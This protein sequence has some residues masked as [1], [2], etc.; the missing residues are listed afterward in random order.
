MTKIFD[1]VAAP[2][3]AEPEAVRKALA[4]LSPS[5]RQRASRFFFE[6]DRRRF[7][8]ARARLRQLLAVR[9]EIQP[10]EVEL[11]YGSHGKPALT[12]SD[13]HFNV[14]H[15]DDLAV[16]A[17]SWGHEIGVD[18]E[19]VRWFVDAGDIALRF[20]SRRENVA[21]AALDPLDKPLGFFNCWT[22]KEAFIKALGDG[23][24]HP[25]DRFD[26]SLAPGEP[27]RILRVGGTAG[28]HCGWTLH[29]LR[30]GPGLIAAI[31]V[32]QVARESASPVG[33]E[34]S[35]VH[36]LPPRFSSRDDT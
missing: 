21:Y 27:A 29:S 31:V 20:F 1:A 16:Y 2:L 24:N 34:R 12:D 11:V 22:R 13:L 35:V 17:F 5:E 23:L 28:D 30:P 14:S 15:C 32:Q 4:L 10:E 19:A 3:D 8:V 26:V 7:I 33:T 36:S 25:L 18:V 9:L 6:R